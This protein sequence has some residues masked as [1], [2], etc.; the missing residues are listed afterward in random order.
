MKIKTLVSAGLMAGL[1][2]AG[3]QPVDAAPPAK[4][5]LWAQEF[6]EAEGA[7]PNSKFFKYDLGGGGWGNIFL[8]LAHVHG[9]RKCSI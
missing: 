8:V 9:G 2:L 5:L 4:K 7:A 1:I 6:N 3:S